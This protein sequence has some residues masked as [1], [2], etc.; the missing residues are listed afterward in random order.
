MALNENRRTHRAGASLPGSCST[1]KRTNSCAVLGFPSSGLWTARLWGHYLPQAPSKLTESAGWISNA[2]Y[3]EPAILARPTKPEIRLFIETATK[4]KGRSAGENNW[5]F[6]STSIRGNEIED[7]PVAP[8]SISPSSVF[9][10]SSSGLRG[11]ASAAQD[12]L[13]R[14]CVPA[15]PSSLRF[16]R[17]TWLPARKMH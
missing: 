5:I 13:I 12:G 14:L 7:N 10:R 17:P 16:Y 6:G 2:E 8:A 11:R 4:I 9:A 15:S 1:S 3:T